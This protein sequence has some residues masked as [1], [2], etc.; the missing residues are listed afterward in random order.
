MYSFFFF[1]SYLPRPAFSIFS[2]PSSSLLWPPLFRFLQDQTH[3]FPIQL[4]AKAI[5]KSKCHGFFCSC[6][7]P[8]FTLVIVALVLV[9]QTTPHITFIGNPEFWHP[10][11]DTFGPHLRKHCHRVLSFLGLI[12][13][14]PDPVFCFFL[15]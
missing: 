5:V 11:H 14:C 4:K 8:L 10:C 3:T 12:L 15:L 9:V 7:L 1:L 2:S 13:D 6:F